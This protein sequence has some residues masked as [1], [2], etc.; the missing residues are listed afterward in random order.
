MFKR[1]PEKSCDRG[2]GRRLKTKKKTAS[3]AL[4]YASIAHG[5]K[6]PLRGTSEQFKKDTYLSACSHRN[7]QN[8]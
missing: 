7:L 1:L 2:S 6:H 4:R 3:V 5:M 8:C